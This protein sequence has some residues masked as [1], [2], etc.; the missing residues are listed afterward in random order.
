MQCINKKIFP[1]I[2]F[3]SLLGINYSQCGDFDIEENYFADHLIG[4]YL[5]SIDINT[6]D[7]SVEYFR[8]TI[9]QKNAEI[10]NLKAHYSLIINSPDLNLFNFEL[11]SGIIDISEISMSQLIFSNLDI[12]FNSQGISGAEFKNE[13]S[14]L[15]SASEL[16]AIQSIILSS[17][18]IPNG[19]YIFNI[20]LKCA[21]D[22]SIV[23][24]SINKTI[25]AYEPIF[26]DL[27]APGGSLQDTSDTAILTTIPLFTW[28]SDYCSQCNYGIRVCIYDPSLHSSLADAIEDSSVLPA[29]QN[30]DFYPLDNNGS[31]SYPNDG[32]F[33]LMVDKLYVWQIQREYDTTLGNTKNKSDIFVFKISSFDDILDDQLVDNPYQDA[34]KELLGYN[35]E[36]LFNNIDGELRGFSV[37]NNTIII[38]N[39]I[40]P[41]S[42]LYDIINKLDEG[43][44]EIL[45]IEVE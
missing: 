44:I 31:F 16:E 40:V 36:E 41:I 23:Y 34:L 5:N 39:Q 28:N 14:N 26:L 11:M 38:N 37:R 6:G 7:S 20:T 17:G 42:N 10:D 13:E 18:K 35:Y 12:N 2:L 24:D 43:E 8:Y 32:A 27:L 33:D 15:A 9:E 29:N 19:T 22:D 4:F 25:E 21:N 45:Q 1:I 3:L 30:L